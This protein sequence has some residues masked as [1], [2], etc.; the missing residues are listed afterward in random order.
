MMPSGGH[1]RLRKGA[2]TLSKAILHEIYDAD[3]YTF[4][5]PRAAG[6]DD[7]SSIEDDDVDDVQQVLNGPGTRSPSDKCSCDATVTIESPS[8]R[9]KCAKGRCLICSSYEGRHWSIT[10]RKE[11]GHA[12]SSNN[13]GDVSDKSQYRP[14]EKLPPRKEGETELLNTI[15]EVCDELYKL[16]LEP[17][18]D[19]NGL[20]IVTGTTASA[21]SQIIRGLIYRYLTDRMNIEKFRGKKRRPHLVT[22]EDPIEKY[23]HL[24]P[25]TARNCGI[26]YTP[27]QKG[28]D[29]TSVSDVLSDALRQ[30]SAVVYVGET[31][32]QNDWPPLMR[33]AAT[34][35]LAFTTA[36]AGSLT[37][38]F[39]LIMKAVGAPSSALRSEMANRILA[40]VHIQKDEVGDRSVLFPALWRRTVSGAN[41][42]MSDG[43][44]SILPN[45]SACPPHHEVSSFGR[46][47][48]AQRL[49]T[50]AE[51]REG[52]K[53]IDKI[54]TDI[55]AAAI[56][57]DLQGI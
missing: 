52:A 37:G 46:Y 16:I 30:T 7:N 57:L 9:T 22:F 55:V 15:A 32:I 24:D 40:V 42:L 10:F 20:V 51:Q 41:A 49:I 56:R 4:Y 45:N 6:Q 36:H 2:L 19:H 12:G 8:D 3:D 44:S 48:F 26:D 23:Y 38:A 17:R 25:D 31:R 27:R 14:K 29:A 54:R 33:F 39:G 50:S 35:H 53:A 28:V 11:S 13:Y 34:G 47:W 43:L 18:G 21:K 1:E 5:K